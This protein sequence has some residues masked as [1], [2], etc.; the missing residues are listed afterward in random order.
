MKRILILLLIL[1]A[2]AVPAFSAAPL[3]VGVDQTTRSDWNAIVASFEENTRIKVNLH[4]YPENSLAQQAVIE[5]TTRAGKINLIMLRNDW[6]R[7]LQRYTIDLSHY[8]QR[9]TDAGAKLMYVSGQPLGVIIPFA[10]D[11]FL[12]L[13]AWP[14]NPEDAISFLSSLTAGPTFATPAPSKVSPEAMIK[15]F[16]TTKI[17]RSEH[18]PKLDGSL[19]AL[20]GAVQSTVGPMTA[21]FMSRLP[22]QAQTALSGL[23]KLYGIPFSAATSTVTVVLETQGGRTSSASV[24]ALSALGVSKSSIEASASLIKVSVPLSQLSTIVNQISGISFIRGPYKPYPLSITGQGIH[25]INAD[26]LHASGV[27][28]S[29][30]KVAIIDL[31]FAGLSQAQSRGDIPVSV[32]QYDVTGTGL[33]S[34]ISH[35][36]AVAEILH[37]IAPD[38]QLYLIKIADEVDLDQAVTYCLNNGIKIISHSLGWYNTNFY[39]G[40]GTVADIAKRAIQGGILW[41]NAAGNE[42]QSHWE[43][44]FRDNNSDGWN[45]QSVSF[46]ASAG[47][48]IILYMTWNDWPKASSDYDLYLYDPSNNVVASSTKHQTGTEE[49]TESIITTASSSGTYHIKVK[50]T[51]GK[52][53]EIYNLYQNLSP[54]IASSSIL[55]PG[56]VDQVVT[57]GAIDYHH[58]S[59]GSQEPYSSQG[60]TN[61]G[62]AKPDLCAPD[63]VT[64]GTSPYTTFAG[65]SGATPHVSGAAALLLSENPSMSESAL[66]SELL[67]ETVS[68]GSPYIYGH[69]RLVLTPIAAPNQSPHAAFNMSTSSTA[70]GSSVSFNASASSD[71]DG[72][73]VNYAWQFGDGASASGVTTQHAYA[74]TG[75][76]T[77]RLTVRDNDGATDTTQQQVHVSTAAK[78]DLVVAGITHSP[79][80]PTIG[81]NITFLVNVKNQGTSNASQFRVKLSGNGSSVNKYVTSLSAGGSTNISLVLPLTQSPETFT[82]TVDDT[83]QVPES[84]EAN[85]QGQETVQQGSQPVAADAG[86]PYSGAPGHAIT[87]N[88]SGSSGPISDYTWN[89]GDGGSA[90]GVNP[91]H[92]YASAGTYTVTLTVTGTG[93]RDTDTAPVTISA[94]APSAGA[95][96]SPVGYTDSSRLYLYPE[97]AYDDNPDSAAFT[98]I[99]LRQFVWTTPLELRLSAPTQCDGVR[100]MVSDDYGAWAYSTIVVD[101]YAGHSWTNV[102]KAP[103]SEG[104]WKTVSFSARAISAMRIT[105]RRNSV[106]RDIKFYINEAQFH[107]LGSAPGPANQP[108]SAAFSYSPSSPNVGQQVTFNGSSSGDS[109]GSIVSYQWNFGDGTGGSGAVVQHAY[110]SSGTYQARLTVIDNDGAS[111]AATH[112]VTVAQAA[113]GLS[114]QLSLP[115]SLYQVGEAIL[116]N[117]TLNREAYVYICEADASGKLSLLY[118]N[119]IERNN[120]VSA[121]THSLPSGGYT[122]RVS[123]PTGNETLYAFAATSPLPNFPTQ[124]SGSFPVLSYNP[125]SFRNSVL[126]TMQSQLPPGE[127]AEDSLGLSVIAQAQSTG[128]LWVRSSPQGAS[129]TI[130]GS[131][132]GTTPTQVTTT[133]GTHT[134]SISLSGY[135]GETRQAPVYAGRTTTVQVL[136]QPQSVGPSATFTVNPTEATVGQGILFDAS[137]STAPSGWIVSYSWDFGDGSSAA[138]VQAVHAYAAPGTYTVRL[139]VSDNQGSTAMAQASVPI[140]GGWM[141][142]P[143]TVGAP[144]MGNT[145]GIFVWGTDTWH[146]TVNAGAGWMSPHSYRLELRTDGS[147]QGVNQ[148]TSGGVVPLGVI[149]TPTEG[150]KTLVF[151]GSLQAGSADYTFTVP[152]SKSVWMS[153]KLDINGD[154][155]LD[156]SESFVYLRT[157]MVHPPVAPF[158]V[159]LP[160][161]SSGPL[162][163]SMN[164]RV[165]RGLT[166]TSSVRFIMWMTSI[167]TLEGH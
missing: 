127:Y 81:A 95:W 155:T 126:Q 11:W 151:N 37:E 136:L 32:Q 61:D 36:T 118:P 35:G 41:V 64:T 15:S 19:E 16:A 152:N 5:K 29:G 12:A 86:G 121:G 114:I 17:A 62:R 116:I 157:M 139:L 31:G 2:L 164:F 130:D 1:S 74:T 39:D 40:T 137:G 50:G 144:A 20:L 140:S 163:P 138:G 58:Y 26:V 105:A 73:I 128:T 38:A 90:H 142:P 147:F 21:N 69:G 122:L 13:I 7:S 125:P 68:M 106:P 103:V 167:N 166:Y 10:P 156:E 51:G 34:G 24:A 110:A 23:A 66:R 33:T 123:E 85:N 47:Q 132:V 134:V 71:S 146:I 28:G 117:Y 25:A 102:Y 67:S 88:G 72:S 135:Q 52:K 148:S 14:G 101:V 129:V 3:S 111:N 56:N 153:L 53:I 63:N 80:Q 30:V 93:T 9:L 59:S 82:V 42:A 75:T 6:A 154:G 18:N 8:E 89:F 124:F 141:P 54:A 143:P 4:P 57:V 161:G 108:P 48:Q 160:S 97:R 60:P 112:N 65:T 99:G 76:F 119:Y 94:P 98:R 159:G 44:T 109:D 145:P 131:F 133:V 87:F 104:T 149:P 55:A 49:P 83:N 78:A 158:V 22:V 115:K 92:A 165:G 113:P 77:V 162:V 46:S 100:F 96:I 45:D 27:T 150:G 107:Q 91:T 120:R 70:V 43:G 84:N 79:A